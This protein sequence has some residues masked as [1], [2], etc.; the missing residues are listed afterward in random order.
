VLGGLILTWAFVQSCIDLL[1]PE[2]SESG[3][4]WLG[5]GPPFVIGIGF[6]L[7]G[8]V[9]MLIQWRV[10]PEFFRRKLEVAGDPV[11]GPAITK[12]LD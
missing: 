3:S 8:V 5:V 6:L 1:D 9:L 12:E 11:R 10:S 7:L 2:N 4:S